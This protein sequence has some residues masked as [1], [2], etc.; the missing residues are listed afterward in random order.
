MALSRID[1]LLTWCTRAGFGSLMPLH[2]HLLQSSSKTSTSAHRMSIRTLSPSNAQDFA[3][4][5]KASKSEA[6]C[7]R[8]CY[9]EHCQEDIC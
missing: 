6:L 9:R 3:D 2:P 8:P 7:C 4:K 5:L 1:C